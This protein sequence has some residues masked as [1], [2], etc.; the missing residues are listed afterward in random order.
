MSATEEQK[1]QTAA[2]PV[3]EKIE[4]V[5]AKEEQEPVSSSTT[6]A[7][8]E[9]VTEGAKETEASFGDKIK[10]EVADVKKEVSKEVDAVEKKVDAAEKKVEEAAKKVD[11]DKKANKLFAPFKKVST[12]IRSFLQ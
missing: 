6:D 1:I 2:E 8:K 11:A 10:K 4:A 12:K 3:E 7:K 5:V 9:E